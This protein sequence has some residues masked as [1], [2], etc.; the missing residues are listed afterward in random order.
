VSG[1]VPV[2]TL[3]GAEASR[4]IVALKR[5]AD[6]ALPF[7]LVGGL[8]VL[9]RLAAVNPYRATGDI[10]AV[11]LGHDRDDFLEVLKGPGIEPAPK[12][13][14]LLIG[15]VEVDIIPTG[16]IDL[17]G[18]ENIPEND[19]IFVLS[20]H[21]AMTTSRPLTIAD[22]T[23]ATATCPT[24]VPPALVAMKLCSVEN[25]GN[26]RPE[27]VAS[28]SR[29]LYFL[30]QQFD[31]DGSIAEAI[32]LGPAPLIP[33][34]LSATQRTLVDGAE[35]MQRRL[36]VYSSA[37]PQPPFADDLIFVGERLIAGLRTA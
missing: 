16:E 24:A 7:T 28:D 27:K 22:G 25:R 15:D 36:L 26:D 35:P 34:I 2:V 37:T 11:T 23:G 13:D 29:D 19:A 17:N 14:R 21:W 18:F 33:L 3:L 30:L 6:D 10:D 20:H 4:L 1:E 31:R 5:L 8:A 32:R 9:A 12:G